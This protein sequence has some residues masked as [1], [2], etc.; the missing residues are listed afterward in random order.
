MNQKYIDMVYGEN[1]LEHHGIQGQKWGVTNGPPYP[2]GRD[3]YDLLNSGGNP[4]Q[5]LK[6]MKSEYKDL[7]KDLKSQ[8]KD[9]KNDYK[10]FK[11]GNITGSQ[12]MD[13]ASAVGK[14]SSELKKYNQDI[15]TYKSVTGNGKKSNEAMLYKYGIDATKVDNKRDQYEMLEKLGASKSEL[16]SFMYGTAKSDVKYEKAYN[17]AKE[18]AEN[19]GMK[20]ETNEALTKVGK[21]ALAIALTAGATYAGYKY[22]STHKEQIKDT[23]KT[24]VTEP[25]KQKAKDTVTEAVK[26]GMTKATGVSRENL[27]KKV[28]SIKTA[29]DNTSTAASIIKESVTSGKGFSSILKNRLYGL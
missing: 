3:V 15:A 26:E 5:L 19:N 8:Q 25:L 24:K 23:I 14:S 4:K 2:L 28:E 6:A 18:R 12:Y 16:K 29:A 1:H 9:L 27:D 22:C 17:E 11:K 20:K 21:T 7:K 10:D 13:K